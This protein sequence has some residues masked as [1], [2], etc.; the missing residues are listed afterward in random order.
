[1]GCALNADVPVPK[2]VPPRPEVPAPKAP[3]VDVPRAEVPNPPV[4]L[5]VPNPVVVPRP[6]AP[7]VLVP[8]GVPNAAPAVRLVPPSPVAVPNGFP[9]DV[10][11]AVPRDPVKP[12]GLVWRLLSPNAWGPKSKEQGT[13]SLSLNF[14]ASYFH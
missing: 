1:L 3:P 12:T 5:V 13:L 8:R 6:V 14:R 11:P 9:R 2:P 4:R 10:V 7:K